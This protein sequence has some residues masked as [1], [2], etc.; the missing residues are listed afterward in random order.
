MTRVETDQLKLVYLSELSANRA[1]RHAAAQAVGITLRDVGFLEADDPG[2]KQK[3][4]QVLEADD[5]LLADMARNALH[6]LI[7]GSDRAKLTAAMYL[8]KTRGGYGQTSK[9]EQVVTHKDGDIHPVSLADYAVRAS[10]KK[11][12]G[13]VPDI[14]AG[15][16]F[17]HEVDWQ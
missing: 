10:A 9:V 17:S 7:Q 8:D 13:S 2:F 14:H 11:I 3:C 12:V 1:D 5:M 15:D 4:S 6:E 16:A